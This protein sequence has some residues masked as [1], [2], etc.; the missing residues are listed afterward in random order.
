MLT[1]R[2]TLLPGLRP[3][4]R[5]RHHVQLG[6]DPGQAV[7][8]ELP[9]PAAAQLFE[10]LD[11]SRTESMII[12]ELARIGLCEAEAREV[13]NNLTG[14]GLVVGAHTLMPSAIPPDRR[15]RLAR[16]AAALALRFR[17]RPATP[18]VILHRRHTARVIIAGDGPVA[19]HLI[20]TLSE[21]GVGTV[22]TVTEAGETA[23]PIVSTTRS[24]TIRADDAF[25]VQIGRRVDA[26]RS[27]GQLRPPR[28]VFG[29]RDGVAIVGPL[30]PPRRGP[31]LRCLDLHRTDRDPAWPQLARQ[32]EAHPGPCAAATLMTAAGFAAAEVLAF[33][34]GGRPTTIGTTVEIDGLAPWRRRTWTPHPSCDCTPPHP[35][36]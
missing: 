6:T 32:L 23:K 34:D 31:C 22:G 15:D 26:G 28:L 13:L 21:A 27:G 17:K 25:V 14:T 20:T 1:P 9:H 12:S 30:V 8:L 16:E 7:V 36:G 2:P 5:D 11:G 19:A 35:S 29:V 33:I 3:L 24:P 10:L 18:A 4:W